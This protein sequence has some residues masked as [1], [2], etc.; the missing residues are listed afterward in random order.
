MCIEECSQLHCE[1]GVAQNVLQAHL[2][3]KTQLLQRGKPD[4]KAGHRKPIF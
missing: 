4:G 2:M 3:E 1:Q